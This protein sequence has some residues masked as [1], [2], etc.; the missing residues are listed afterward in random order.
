MI[1][2]TLNFTALYAIT[3]NISYGFLVLPIS[4]NVSYQVTYIGNG[5]AVVI[6]QGF[7]K[8]GNKVKNVTQVYKLN[9]S[10]PLYFFPF[11][12]NQTLRYLS[13][14][15]NTTR[16]GHLMKVICNRENSTQVMI[17]DLNK[18]VVIKETLI[19]RG[20]VGA[21]TMVMELKKLR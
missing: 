16:T 13:Y 14:M 9:L 19:I 1:W 3:G 5:T 21:I 8:I 18:M 6:S 10:R 12:T 11:T 4:G 2:L 20:R 15:C 17:V 7:M